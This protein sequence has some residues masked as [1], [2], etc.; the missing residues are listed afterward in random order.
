MVQTIKGRNSCL[1]DRYSVDFSDEL[2]IVGRSL[3]DLARSV[4]DRSYLVC[5]QNRISRS[6][7]I[8]SVSDR[9]DRNLGHLADLLLE[10]HAPEYLLDLSL[11]RGIIRNSALHLRSIAARSCKKGSRREDNKSVQFHIILSLIFN[12]SHK[13]TKIS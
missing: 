6:S 4:E 10:S 13:Y 5:T 11:Y 8:H 2:V 12:K 1:L 7:K 9:S 3:S